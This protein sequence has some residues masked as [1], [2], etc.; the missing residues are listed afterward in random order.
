MVRG[1]KVRAVVSCP[2]NDDC[3]SPNPKRKGQKAEKTQTITRFFQTVVQMDYNEAMIDEKTEK[4]EIIDE[5][6]ILQETKLL[7]LNSTPQH[8]DLKSTP[9][10]IEYRMETARNPTISLSIEKQQEQVVPVVEKAPKG[11]RKPKSDLGNTKLTEFFPVR[12][13]IRKTKKTVLEEK[14]KSLED[15]VRSGSEDGLLVKIFDGK[16]RGVVTTKTFEK[17]DFVVEYSGDLIDLTEANRREQKYSL[18][19][20]AGCYMYYFKYRNQQYW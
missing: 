20:T 7:G 11:K 9:H 6:C 16:G 10:R 18:D 4:F 5:E 17:G 2:E 15:A 19:H 14:Q 1:R 12:R 13:S 3:Y 8:Y